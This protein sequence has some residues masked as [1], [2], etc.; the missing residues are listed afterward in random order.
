V[1][2]SDGT[3]VTT[4]GTPLRVADDIDT[5]EAER[6]LVAHCVG[7]LESQVALWPGQFNGW[8]MAE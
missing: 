5:D 7:L 1:R 3:F 6:R 2:Q 4:I 8:G